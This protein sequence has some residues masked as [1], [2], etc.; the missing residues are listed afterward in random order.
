MMVM[1]VI[2]GDVLAHPRPDGSARRCVRRSSGMLVVFNFLDS[3]Q[4]IPINAHHTHHSS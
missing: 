4:N 3:D 1:M 2:D